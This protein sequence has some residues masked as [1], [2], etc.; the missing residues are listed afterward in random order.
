DE[1]EALASLGLGLD[2]QFKFLSLRV[3]WGVPLIN[4][5]DR[6]DSLQDNGFSFSLQLQ[7]F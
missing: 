2:W 7:P 3:D 4:T 1:A 6:G 5:S